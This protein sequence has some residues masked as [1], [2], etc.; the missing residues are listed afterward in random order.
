MPKPIWWIL[1]VFHHFLLSL[2]GLYFGSFRCERNF[3]RPTFTA[4]RHSEPAFCKAV[5]M[6]STAF[7][8]VTLVPSTFVASGAV[9]TFL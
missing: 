2:L 3:F 1:R 8:Q 6:A 9:P 7:C 4:K 5:F